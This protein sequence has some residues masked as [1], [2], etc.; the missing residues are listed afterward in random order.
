MIIINSAYSIGGFYNTTL[1]LDPMIEFNMLQFSTE[2]NFI[3]IPIQTLTKALF[4]PTSA[5][6]LKEVH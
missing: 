1:S 6:W 3:K 4:K 5:K 2:S